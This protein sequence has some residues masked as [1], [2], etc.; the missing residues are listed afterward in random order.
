MTMLED[1]TQQQPQRSWLKR[2]LWSVLGTLIVLFVALAIMFSTDRG[3]QFLLDRV[4]K[5]QSM[6]SY[7]YESG[8]FLSGLMLKNLDIHLTDLDVKMKHANVVIGWR[9]I[10]NKEVHFY[11]ANIQELQII[12]K[13]PPKNTPFDFAVIDMPVTLRLDHANV[14]KL[15]LKTTTSSTEIKNIQLNNTLWKGTKLSFKNTSLNILDQVLVKQANGQMD[16]QHKYPL[17]ATAQVDLPSLHAMNIKDIFVDVRG[18]LDALATGFAVNTPDLLT[19]RMLIHPVRDNVP[20]QGQINFNQYHWPIATDQKLFTEAGIARLQG[21][22]SEMNIHLSTDLQ[23]VDVPKGQYQSELNV[24]Y[25]HQLNIKQFTGQLMGGTLDLN[26]VLN[27][28]KALAW[29]IK[30]T[31]QGLKA[32][33]KSIPQQLQAYLPPNMNGKLGA[34]GSLDQGMHL[35][36]FVD[37]DKYEKI[38]LKL[39]QAV[40][41]DPKKAPPLN[42]LVNWQNM[43]RSFPSVGWLNSPQGEATIRLSDQNTELSASAKIVQHAQSVLPEGLYQT[44]AMLKGDHVDVSELKL[45]TP[46]GGLTGQAQVDLPTKKQQLKWTAQ[47]FVKNFNPQTVSASAPLD[48]LNGEIHANGYA[49]NNDQFIEL[50]RI[51]LT[52]QLAQQKEI[53]HLTG[54]STTAV[55][56][57]DEK[58]GGGLKGYGVVY[59][60]K[61]TSSQYQG[62]DGVLSFK[63]SGTPSSVEINRFQHDGVAGKIL[64][65]GKVNFTKG[66]AWDINTSLIRFKPQY[67]VSNVR[68]EVSGVVNSTGVWADHAQ[69][70]RINDLNLAGTIN[71][72]IL[73]GKGK[74]SLVMN[75]KDNTLIPQQFEAN[76]FFLAYAGNQAQITGNAQKLQVKLNAPYLNRVYNGLRGRAYGV[77]NVQTQP[78]IQAIAN[79]NVDGFGFGDQLNVEKIRLRGELPTSET[80][81][82]KLQAEIDGLNYGERQIQYGAV[83]I[84]GTPKAHLVSVQGWNKYSKLYVQ[85]SGGFNQDHDWLGQIQKGNF[86]S[87]RASL[88]QQQNANVVYRAATQHLYISEHCWAS[89]QSQLCF[90][91]PIQASPKQGDISFIANRLNLSDFAAFMPDGL[92]MTGELNGYAKANWEQGKA[93]HLDA[94][95]TAQNGRI[96]ITSDDP[97]DAATTTSYQQLSVFARSVAEGLQ[98]RFDVKTQNIGNGYAS[99]TIDPYKDQLPMQGEAAFSQVDLQFLKP[100]IPDARRIGGTLDFAAK[101]NGTVS[102]PL[103]TGDLR[104]KDGLISMISTPVNLNNIQMYSA[105]R[106]DQATI[107]GIFNSGPGVGKID[108]L[109]SWRND[110]HIQLKVQGE[111]LLV[112]QA[113]L[114]TAL[115]NTVMNVD[116]YPN[117]RSVTVK[118]NIE[119]PRAI[120]NMPETSPDVIN[121]S[122][123]ARVVRGGEDLIAVLKAAK[124][125]NVQA[126]IDFSLG[127]RVIF[128]GFNSRIP[129]TGR[130]YLS[131][132][133]L[134]T[135]MSANGAIGVSQ[136]VKIESYGQTLDLN[137]A[138]ARFNGPLANPTLDIDTTK[139][140]SNTTLG[141]RITG[142]ATTPNI[143]IYNDGG[144]SEQEALNALLTGRINQGSSSLSQTEG[145]KS[146]VN[147][148]LAAAGIS[149]GLGGTRAFTNQIGHAFGLSGLAL[150]AQGTGDDTQVSVTGYIT[151]DLYLRYGVGVFTAVNKLTLRYQINKRL[152]LEAS[153]SVERAVDIFYNWR[154]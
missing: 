99:V 43:N 2:I 144:L 77:V 105:I 101:I 61:L 88:K 41:Q 21:T 116:L 62:A 52:G 114:I 5:N 153:E 82:T 75:N 20:M 1:N 97:D 55:L 42:V 90:D 6:M 84:S 40:Q 109:V 110:P 25:V 14:D 64:A 33:E 119:V 125:W 154:F 73:R 76:D 145:F 57:N 124:P 121:V 68:G 11:K 45:V 123:D 29:D 141:V 132:R 53:V 59:D 140:I 127:D 38:Q 78:N 70:I 106:Q 85:L 27:W 86:D 93:P 80:T 135:A 39:N 120:I 98:V 60:G 142:T 9:A 47:L 36:A 65:N 50:N 134:E 87:L 3:S 66:V 92:A 23:G 69:H 151:P 96:G 49:K 81:P 32:T 126:D 19:G 130:L 128:Q 111:N 24:D 129:L 148:T 149:L 71:N 79:L 56:M 44:K 104:L 143:Q 22:A 48:V 94:K 7:Q 136:K 146:D 16:F 117:Q 35:N 138:I 18:T 13:K 102:K 37:F 100:F 150:D 10:F 4:L 12:N 26:G 112:K 131:Q 54:K 58:H 17:Q 133:G 72:Q 89:N 8:S 108:G 28:D 122:S 51:D 46:Q 15:E 115:V 137:R 103:V 34:T 63:V 147:N 118:G 74:L 83:T 107:M 91:K 95:I 30:G 31:L 113:P 67:F 139:K 152:Y